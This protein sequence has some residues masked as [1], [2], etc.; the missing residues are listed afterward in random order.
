MHLPPAYV[1][2]AAPVRRAAFGRIGGA[3]RLPAVVALWVAAI[4]VALF[5]LE[6]ADAMLPLTDP[7]AVPP[8]GVFHPADIDLDLIDDAALQTG[9]RRHSAVVSGRWAPEHPSVREKSPE[10]VEHV[11]IM[12]IEAPVVARRVLPP[13]ASAAAVASGTMRKV[14]TA[15]SAATPSPRWVAL[16]AQARSDIGA[17][18]FGAAYA[19]LR[20]QV[21]S[22][23]QDTEYLGLLAL[24]ALRLGHQQEA[25]VLY[26][27]LATL[28]PGSGRWRTGLAAADP[29]SSPLTAPALAA[30]A[31][32]FH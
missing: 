28:E 27:H 11:V 15:P 10:P 25:E 20:P 14:P 21:A 4:T 24:A 8:A 3:M 17:G 12:E 29:G 19:K 5:E 2:P 6:S 16:K 7:L 13:P 30:A 22:A 32:G 26:R 23:R 1:P 18:R 9:L 31:P